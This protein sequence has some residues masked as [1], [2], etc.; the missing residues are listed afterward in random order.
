MKM[1]LSILFVSLFMFLNQLQP[2]DYKTEDGNEGTITDT[3]KTNPLEGTND[4]KEQRQKCFSLSYSD[5]FQ[6]KCC[7]DSTNKLCFKWENA[8]QDE[9]CP[10]DSVIYNN[11]GMAGIYQ[12]IIETTCTEI[13]LVQGY[14]CFATFDDGSTACIRTKELNKNKNSVTK[15]MENYLNNVK[16]KNE[17]LKDKN[18]ETIVCKGY[19]LKYYLFFL[20]LFIISL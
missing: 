10:K 14:C 17:L 20:I 3:N 13:S 12:P 7:Y 16:D 5:I 2:C 6:N 4:E 11:C 15:D 18:Y 9:K 8:S 1:L 19:H